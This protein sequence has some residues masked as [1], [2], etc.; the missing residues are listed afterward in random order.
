MFKYLDIPN[1]CDHMETV[2]S[3]A[4]KGRHKY[5]SNYIKEYTTNVRVD[6]REINL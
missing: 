6:L 5:L 4:M 1:E 2:D 3:A